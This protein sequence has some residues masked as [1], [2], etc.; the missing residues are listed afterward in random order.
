MEH[1]LGGRLKFE[2]DV[3]LRVRN[4]QTS[5][6]GDKKG[7]QKAPAVCNSR[8]GDRDLVVIGGS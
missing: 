4:W 7:A 1:V 5:A 6:G 2:K 3:L 8:L